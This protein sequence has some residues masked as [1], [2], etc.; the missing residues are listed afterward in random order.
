MHNQPLGE[1]PLHGPQSAL[2]GPHVHGWPHRWPHQSQSP[3][4]GPYGTSETSSGWSEKPAP[5]RRRRGR[6]ALYVAGGFLGLAVL[7]GVVEAVGGGDD[8]QAVPSPAAEPSTAVPQPS[9]GVPTPT[10]DVRAAYLAALEEIDPGLVVKPDRAVSRGRE[11]CLD[12]RDG[13]PIADVVRRTR[14]RFSGG[15][16][17][18]DNAQARQVVAAVRKWCGAD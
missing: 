5:P 2:Q 15:T 4:S 12:L 7:G 14:Q 3:V 18:I 6:W 1:G 11:V 8:G 10:G 13:V 9:T 16:T 17:T